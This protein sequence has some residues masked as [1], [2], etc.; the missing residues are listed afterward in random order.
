MKQSKTLDWA[1]DIFDILKD[2]EVPTSD[3]EWK[4]RLEGLGLMVK[5]KDQVFLCTI[6]GLVLFGVSPRRYIKQSGLRVMAFK[7]KDKE[8]QAL[9]DRVLDGPTVG[10][11]QFG[12]EGKQLVDDGLIEKCINFLEPFISIES[13]TIDRY[14]RREKRWKYPLDAVR[15]TVINALTHRDWTRFV[16]IEITVYSDRMEVI[17][18]GSLKNSMTIEKMKTGQ[19]SI[20]NQIIVDVLKDYGYVDARG[21]GIRT[22]VIPLMKATGREPVFEATEDYLKT[23]LNDA[24]RE[25]KSFQ[26][27]RV[28]EASIEGFDPLFFDVKADPIFNRSTGQVSDLLKFIMLYPKANY[29]QIAVALQVSA[30]TVKRKIQ[31]LKKENRLRRIGSKKTGFWEVL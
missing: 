21:M 26:V 24:Q 8:Y 1:P 13:P 2:P 19:R 11:W 10:R 17:S 15:E 7:G 12:K 5:N 16:D 25:N 18:P 22:K 4:E 6:A 20:R 29:E 28:K 23:I 9:M 30:A 3:T 31:T 27:D 14:F